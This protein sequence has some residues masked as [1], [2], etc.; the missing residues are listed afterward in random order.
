M[1]AAGD[2]IDDR[3]LFPITPPIESFPQPVRRP[4]PS[5]N[6]IFFRIDRGISDTAQN[7]TE[8]IVDSGDLLSANP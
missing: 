1:S 7:A 8:I 3:Q 2:R 5:K 4:R 6:L